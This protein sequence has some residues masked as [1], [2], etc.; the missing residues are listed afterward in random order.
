MEFSFNYLN[1]IIGLFSVH[2]LAKPSISLYI[3]KQNAF[4]LIA[5]S[6]NHQV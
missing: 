4:T 3:D 1:L 5:I 2:E 6:L